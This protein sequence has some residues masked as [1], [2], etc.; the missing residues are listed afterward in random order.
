MSCV[1]FCGEAVPM[2]VFLLNYL[3]KESVDGKEWYEPQHG[4]K[5]AVSSL[6]LFGCLTFMK[7]M[8]LFQC[9]IETL[10]PSWAMRQVS[11]WPTAMNT[12]LM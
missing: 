1:E 3:P 6:H 2:D 12:C 5:L 7:K 4:K 9:K 8:K 10:P 11:G